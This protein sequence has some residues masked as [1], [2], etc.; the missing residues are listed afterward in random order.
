MNKNF[1]QEK[2]PPFDILRVQGNQ[3]DDAINI[4]QQ[5]L[6]QKT[7]EYEQQGRT[8]RPIGPPTLLKDDNFTK[9]ILIMWELPYSVKQFEKMEDQVGEII[10]DL[11]NKIQS[12]FCLHNE[13]YENRGDGKGLV[14]KKCG[15][16]L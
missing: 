11:T 10:T 1:E 6:L 14:C 4:L 16:P 13:G 5:L 15:Q 2:R 9:I 12:E 7:R 8:L 3:F